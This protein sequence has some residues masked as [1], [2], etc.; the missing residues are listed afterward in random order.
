MTFKLYQAVLR[1]FIE[2]YSPISIYSNGCRCVQ[3]SKRQVIFPPRLLYVQLIRKQ[4][5]TGTKCGLLSLERLLIELY[6]LNYINRT[7]KSI[8]SDRVNLRSFFTIE[9]LDKN[10]VLR[11][12]VICKLA[13]IPRCGH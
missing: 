10:H 2:F 13:C 3:T 5:C 9:K 12:N 7:N 11:L 4:A 6:F 8:N 1:K